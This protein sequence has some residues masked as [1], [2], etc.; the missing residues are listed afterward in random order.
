MASPA[1]IAHCQALRGR[2]VRAFHRSGRACDGV[3]RGVEGCTAWGSVPVYVDVGFPPE[4]NVAAEG[5]VTSQGNVDGQRAWQHVLSLHHALPRSDMEDTVT[6]P[7]ASAVPVRNTGITVQAVPMPIQHGGSASLMP[8]SG[9]PPSGVPP[10]GEPPPRRASEW[11]PARSGGGER[12]REIWR[13]RK[14]ERGRGREEELQ[15]MVDI[16][17]R[18]CTA[19]RPPSARRQLRV[20]PTLGRR[21]ANA[22]SGSA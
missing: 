4:A 20:G 12:R 8:P 21:M 2:P 9:V 18:Q 5:D 6:Q 22:A 15:E 17:K 11:K 10:S 7:R 13:E 3:D 1:I 16:E 19:E 14:H